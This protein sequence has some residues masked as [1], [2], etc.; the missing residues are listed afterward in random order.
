[1]C[2]MLDRLETIGAETLFITDKSNREAVRREAKNGQPPLTIP[3][4]ITGGKSLPEDIYAPIP[5]VIPAQ[6]FAASL[7]EVKGLDA[8]RPRSLN[9]VTQTL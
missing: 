5:Y 9:K 1:M 6:L 2:E 3:L 7:A 4:A 8:D